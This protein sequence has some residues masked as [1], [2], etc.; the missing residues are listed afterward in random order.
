MVEAAVVSSDVL[1]YG[2]DEKLS[3]GFLAIDQMDAGEGEGDRGEEHATGVVEVGACKNDTSGSRSP[4]ES[5]RNRVAFSL[6]KIQKKGIYTS[7][8][9]TKLCPA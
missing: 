7:Q 6:L 1:E 4:R 9:T 3:F 5:S 2:N 8:R